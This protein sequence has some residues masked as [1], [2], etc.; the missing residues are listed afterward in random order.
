MKP[1][2]RDRSRM[3]F[4]SLALHL[5]V[6]TLLVASLGCGSGG[7]SGTN[8]DPSKAGQA[9]ITQLD[10]DGSDSISIQEMAE[11]SAFKDSFELFDLE[12]DGEVSA[13]DA[14]RRFE[15]WMEGP[16]FSKQLSCKVMMGGSP[17]QGATVRLAPDS[18]MGDNWPE[19]TATTN[20]E[21]IAELGND[22]KSKGMA[23]VLYG[24][25]KV[26][27]THPSKKISG[28]FNTSTEL[29]LEVAPDSYAG[30]QVEFLVN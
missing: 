13:A 2:F 28:S 27:I 11:S 26:E 29:R 22:P 6:L 1:P 20:A 24:L 9:L 15:L 16:D 10:K 14:A 19:A 21:G 4:P 30:D 3:M 25:Y 5:A 23:M 8:F 12:G 18:L 17:L 7:S